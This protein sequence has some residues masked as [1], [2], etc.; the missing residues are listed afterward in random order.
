MYFSH[1]AK[2]CQLL[3]LDVLWR[4]PAVY[5]AAKGLANAID[6]SLKFDNYM[7]LKLSRMVV[8]A[9]TLS[10]DCGKFIYLAFLYVLLGPS[11]AIPA[12]RAPLALPLD[13]KAPQSAMDFVG[14]RTVSGGPPGLVPS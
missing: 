9:E 5:G 7:T 12:R 10:T 3:G 14:L 6:S 11:E 4:D 13:T 8:F 2:A 1:R